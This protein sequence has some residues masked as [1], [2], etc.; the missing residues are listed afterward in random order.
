MIFTRPIAPLSVLALAMLGG[1]KLTVSDPSAKPCA[2][3]D[4]CTSGLA[5]IEG[6]CSVPCDPLLSGKPC[7][8][9][10]GLCQRNG[11]WLCRAGGTLVCDAAPGQATA[12]LCDGLDN[13]CD[14]RVDEPWPDLFFDC[15]VGVGACERN[16]RWECAAD[17]S[18]AVCSTAAGAPGDELCNGL[19]DD[20]D[21]VDDGPWVSELGTP[22]TVGVGA[23]SAVGL[24]VCSDDGE[25]TRCSVAP[26]APGTETCNGIDDNCDAAT[27][28]EWSAEL[29][30]PCSVG[31][32]ECRADGHTICAL[33][34]TGTACDASPSA[35]KAETCDGRDEDCNGR[36]DDSAPHCVSSWAGNGQAPAQ[37]GVPEQAAFAGPWG[38]AP[39]SA[40][41]VLVADYQ[42][43]R[44]RLLAPDPA[45]LGAFLSVSTLAGTGDSGYADGPG[46]T[47]RFR[48]PASI[49]A[50]GQG[51]LFIADSGNGCVRRLVRGAGGAA[52]VSSPG[53]GVCTSS[54][55]TLGLLS[56]PRGVAY[57]PA[58]Q[59]VYVADT[60]NNRIVKFA[61]QPG[62]TGY[63]AT[64]VGD[65][66]L[67]LNAPEGV[68]LGDAGELLVADTGGNRVVRVNLAT[69]QLLAS[70]AVSGARSVYLDVAHYAIAAGSTGLYQIN[71][72]SA[73][74]SVSRF[75]QGLSWG[76][77]VVP[78]PSGTVYVS[79]RV[80]YRIFRV[81]LS[82][83]AIGAAGTS[84]GG[85][86]TA[87]VVDGPLEEARL[88]GPVALARDA[89]GALYFCDETANVVRKV[90][91]LQVTTVVGSGAYQAADGVGRSVMMRSPAG[92]AFT[93]QGKMVV[94]DRANHCLRI[95]SSAAGGPW[96]VELDLGS[97]AGCGTALPLN[98]P[99]DIAV[100]SS[101]NLYV[102]NKADH[103]VVRYALAAGTYSYSVLAGRSATAGKVDGACASAR[104]SS[105]SA[106]ALDEAQGL[107]YVA[108]AGNSAVR[109]IDLAA[110][111]SEPGCVTTVVGDAGRG[112]VDG[113]LAQAKLNT[114]QGLR[115]GPDGRL[116]LADTSNRR[117]RA[118][119]LDQGSIATLS[120]NGVDA[121]SDGP[122]D[123]AS[124][125]YPVGLHVGGTAQAPLLWVAD[126]DNHA[127]RL[128][129][130]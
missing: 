25:G 110:D 104:F 111:P 57:D 20:C 29:G 98:Q 41:E 34:G 117:I 129:I 53:L 18:G 67:T 10:A 105:P 115:L 106:L 47:A 71:F 2:S 72:G 7:S 112:F 61:P 38:L 8:A 113:P 108:D 21:G 44:I 15:T 80:G 16:G 3:D 6:A 43:Q 125:S 42:A 100:D 32:G 88:A 128:V 13:N 5:C 89:A 121:L 39:G 96:T 127:L 4:G 73:T 114:P 70:A 51:G 26:G 17:L 48:F 68:A 93:A 74:P 83:G 90:D 109:R 64:R 62:G 11:T 119:D 123:E 40:G 59:A 55:S 92:L 99:A 87:A 23:C 94:A 33:E 76:S 78:G 120:G 101:G 66:S 69:G 19:D 126:R 82:G 130:P 27:D 46:H 60:G 54:G 31:I 28:E 37:D 24:T 79:D 30:T 91:G 52:T 124:Y 118:I 116:Y 103:T 63:D 102:A 36:T 107:L 12:E 85:I 65:A 95:L 9:G 97:A 58:T 49:A 50:D 45:K 77:A 1:C 22:C 122:L 84:S 86:G 81:W 75:Y 35:S 14:G 56:N